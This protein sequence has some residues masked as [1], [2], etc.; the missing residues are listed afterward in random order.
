MTL[1]RYTV[2]PGDRVL[3]SADDPTCLL[4][5]DG[6]PTVVSLPA[7]LGGKDVAVKHGRHDECPC[8]GRHQVLILVLDEPSGI[9][10]AECTIKGYLW[11]RP[12]MERRT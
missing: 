3:Q 11:F 4:I 2:S 12:K 5:Y 8:G 7:V 10:V 6:I 1:M 9:Q